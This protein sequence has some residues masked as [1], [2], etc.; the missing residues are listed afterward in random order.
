MIATET[1]SNANQVPQP[2]TPGNIFVPAGATVPGPMIGE[3]EEIKFRCCI[4]PWMHLTVNP[5][6]HVRDRPREHR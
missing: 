2:P 3:E 5:E 1:T 4:H 6:G